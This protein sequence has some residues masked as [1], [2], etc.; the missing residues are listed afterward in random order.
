M[1]FESRRAYHAV[2]GRHRGATLVVVKGAPESVLP[3]CTTW[4]R[5]GAVV[6]MDAEA[7]RVAEEHLHG[8][9]RRGLRVLA[10]ASAPVAGDAVLAALRGAA[11][12]LMAASAPAL[13]L[14]SGSMPRWRIRLAC[15]GSTVAARRS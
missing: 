6:A 15:I 8:L 9:T 12:G 11:G 13:A 2:L 7:L 10:V 1:P 5:D 3:L 4:R 14:V